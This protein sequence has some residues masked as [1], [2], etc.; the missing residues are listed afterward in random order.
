M[1]SFAKT[2]FFTLL[3]GGGTALV[4]SGGTALAAQNV[5]NT[6]QKGSLLIWPFINIAEGE[7]TIIEISND[8]TGPVKVECYY[9]NEK[10][11]GVAFDFRL[12][13]KATAS[14]AVGSQDGD[15]VQPPPFPSG[16][17]YIPGTGYAPVSGDRGALICFATNT[18]ETDQIAWNHLTGTATVVD[19]EDEEGPKY[20][21]YTF[22]YNAWS[23][24]ARNAAGLP[25]ANNVLQG[26]AGRLE[27][28]GA[29]AGTYD[30]C[31]AYNIANFMPNG[32]TLFTG[33]TLGKPTTKANELSVVSCNQDLRQDPNL[34]L[35]KLKFTVW[36]SLESSYRGAFICVDSVNT[37]E[38]DTESENLRNGSN[39]EYDTLKTPNARFQVSGV[40]SPIQCPGSTSSA[41]LGLLQ[42]E[43]FLPTIPRQVQEV[44]ST[45]H[46]AGAASGFVL[47][48]PS[49]PVP[50]K[51]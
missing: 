23:F 40:A 45:T 46:G 6:S 44:A 50:H 30:A 15:Q 47:W 4:L 51:P 7:D 25:E 34:N 49:L 24:V 5:A 42:S 37:V 29:G 48:D 17:S 43:V 32:A 14:W 11:D 33:A 41:L 9:V 10:K 16:G 39:F 20:L 31:P 19:E 26:T 13:G 38:L 3:L 36:N 8:F 21:K 28:T 18:G 27:L 22:R 12:S 2:L 35:T 1:R